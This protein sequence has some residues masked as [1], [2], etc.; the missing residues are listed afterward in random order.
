VVPHVGVR[1]KRGPAPAG[2][3]V[4]ASRSA[5]PRGVG[6]PGDKIRK[7]TQ[8]PIHPEAVPRC[9][10]PRRW[11]WHVHHLSPN[12]PEVSTTRWPAKIRRA[13]SPQ[14]GCVGSGG[15][16]SRRPRI[17]ML[18]IFACLDRLFLGS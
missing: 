13:V 11:C 8:T 1:P 16:A 17:T 9:A 7:G 5:K 14:A 18:R 6:L 10:W 12:L 2:S 3:A 4:R 15:Q